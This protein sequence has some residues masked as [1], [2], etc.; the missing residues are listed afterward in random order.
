MIDLDKIDMNF[1]MITFPKNKLTFS[2]VKSIIN[3]LYDEYG[4]QIN[5]CEIE[6]TDTHILIKNFNKE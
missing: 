2:N 1:G 3:D 4:D 5:S 6:I